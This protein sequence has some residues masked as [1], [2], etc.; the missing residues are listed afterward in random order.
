M[1]ALRILSS[2][3]SSVL[4]M[5][6]AVMGFTFMSRTVTLDSDFAQLYHN[7]YRDKVSICISFSTAY[8]AIIESLALFRKSSDILRVLKPL[9]FR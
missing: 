3:L 1:S 5:F 7:L 4:I 8:L 6:S 9:E 2:A